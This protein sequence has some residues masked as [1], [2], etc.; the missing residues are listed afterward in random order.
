MLTI[1]LSKGRVAKEALPLLKKAGL[2]I[3]EKELNSRKLTIDTQDPNI[4]LLIIRAM[5]VAVFVQHGAADIGIVG[6]DVLL[7]HGAQNLYELLDLKIATCKLT[8][9]AKNKNVLLNVNTLKIATKYVKLT[10]NYFNSQ[11]QQ[12]EIIKLYGAIEL[13]P[14]TG[15][16]HCIVDLTDTGDTLKANG[17]IAIKHIANISSRLIV[18]PA[19]LKTKNKQIKP[20]LNKIKAA[21]L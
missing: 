2:V 15:L 20:L 5:D 16:A 7:E 12:V 6:K 3:N 18:N 17:L 19:S 10:V 13:A 14:K 9:A 21:V 4:K 11:N 1:A 8:L